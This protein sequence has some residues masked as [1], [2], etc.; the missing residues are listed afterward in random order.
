MSGAATRCAGPPLPL[1]LPFHSLKLL[2][3]NNSELLR[4][5]ATAPFRG[6]ATD[7]L[8]VTGGL[9][10]IE[11][12]ARER[13]VLVMLDAEMSDISGYEA[14]RAI[15]HANEQCRVVLVL[16]GQVSA[17]QM[18][19]VAE[20][21][22][23]EVLIAPVDADQLYDMVAAQ[24]K[25]PRRA[26]RRHDVDLAVRGQSGQ[27]PIRGRATNLSVGGARLMLHDRIEPGAL[28]W[29]EVQP[30]GEP[31]IAV[32]ARAVWAHRRENGTAV[33]AVFDEMAQGARHH[34]ARITQWDI[35][36]GADRT[37]VVLR[38][39]ITESTL[40]ADL[41]PAL[42]GKIDFD[43]SQVTYMNALGVGDWVAFLSR[44]PIRD[45]EFHACSV[46][47]ALQA[48]LVE[49]VLGRGS[50][51]SFFAPYLCQECD[52]QEE[53]L[54]QTAAVLAAGHPPVFGCSRCD[55][56]LVLDDFPERYTA[57]LRGARVA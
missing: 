6:Q 48:S 53:R 46:A 26:A 10:A 16:S 4:R 3:S 1:V 19:L 31:P 38:G 35:I 55:G 28:F 11:L 13:P 50:V 42:F 14:A 25:L 8:M 29:L 21:G 7:L 18:R 34:L 45:Y 44:L 30:E 52:H 39:D 51:A 12:A 54:L 56:P 22:T 33:G 20:S 27:R 57:F 43:M 9:E 17:R 47:F 41:A 24:L 15:K 32:D 37:R 23:D 36:Q 49:G 2:V 5:L 40:L